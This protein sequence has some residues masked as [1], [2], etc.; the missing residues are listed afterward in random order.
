MHNKEVT[1]NKEAMKFIENAPKKKVRHNKEVMKFTRSAQ[2]K[3]DTQQG[4]D[5]VH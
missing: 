5:E 1:H 2:Q 3:G 4:G